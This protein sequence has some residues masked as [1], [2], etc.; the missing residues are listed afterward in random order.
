MLYGMND[1]TLTEWQIPGLGCGTATQIQSR[2][3][4]E[5]KID[6]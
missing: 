3:D 5:E 1:H 2:Q 6:V 4:V